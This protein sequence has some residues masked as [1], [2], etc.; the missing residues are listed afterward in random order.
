ME[1]VRYVWQ[2][3]REMLKWVNSWCFLTYKSPISILCKILSL[4]E[5]FSWTW[6]IEINSD[7]GIHLII[8]RKLSLCLPILSVFE[9]SFCK[10]K[11][12]IQDF[13]QIH[14]NKIVSEFFKSGL[15]NMWDVKNLRNFCVFLDLAQLFVC[16]CVCE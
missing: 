15:H 6:K 13:E 12:M 5:F 7:L 3:M 2:N 14:A 10:C 11:C 8:Y 1:K 16:F 4:I 9:S